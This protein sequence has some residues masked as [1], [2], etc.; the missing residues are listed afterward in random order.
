MAEYRRYDGSGS[1]N[2]DANWTP[3]V[4]LGV[5][6]PEARRRPERTLPAGERREHRSSPASGPE[7]FSGHRSPSQTAPT[8]RPAAFQDAAGRLHAVFERGDANGLHL[9]HA[10][11]DDGATWRSGTVATQSP[12]D[13]IGDPRVA[14]APDHVG[15]AVWR[16][17]KRSA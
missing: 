9:V 12:P 6:S 5:A 14:T 8:R 13:G 15:V 4:E 7:P 17:G 10:V 16:A 3:A 2:D 11:S 1:L